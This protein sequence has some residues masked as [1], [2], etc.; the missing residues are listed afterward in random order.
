MTNSQIIEIAT[1]EIE[2]KT[3]GA[4]EQLLEVHQ[5][6]YVDNKPKVAR[7]DTEKDDGTVIVYFPIVDQKFYLAVYLDT[8]PQI[9]VR[10][11]HTEAYHSVYFR[12]TSEELNFKELSLLTKL[13]STGGWDKGDKKK[14][15]NSF[16][17]FASLAFEPNPEADEFHDKLEKLIDFL[18]NDKEGIKTLVDKAN[19]H[20][21]VATCFYNGNT[22]LGGYHLDK[23]I[24]KRLGLLNLEN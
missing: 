2:A 24:I 10:S 4:T 12:A 18:E 15:G 19:G 23:N 5:V 3:F 9:S 7:L 16:Y 11:I 1:E 20:I 17:K 21:Q 14:T 13:K 8:K 22:M 6:V